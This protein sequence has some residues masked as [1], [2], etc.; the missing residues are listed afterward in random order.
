VKVQNGKN[1]SS[2]VSGWRE[3]FVI[4]ELEANE[5]YEVSVR[6]VDEK[7][8]SVGFVTKKTKTESKGKYLTHYFCL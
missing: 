6:T 1:L 7:G 8:D 3:S 2:I 5:E 4:A